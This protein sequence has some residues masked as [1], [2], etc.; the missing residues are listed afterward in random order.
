MF[1][2]PI[3]PLR[4]AVCLAGILLASVRSE[5]QSSC[6]PPRLLASVAIAASEFSLADLFAPGTCAGFMRNAGSIRLGATPLSGSP[7]VFSSDEMQG[8]L[9]RLTGMNPSSTLDPNSI[10]VPL[11]ITV[12]RAAAP[13]KPVAPGGGLP[14]PPVATI[15]AARNRIPPP[16]VRAGSKAQLLWDRD[17]IRMFIPVICLDGGQAGETVR[18]RPLHGGRVLPA[19]I[20]D[21]GLVRSIS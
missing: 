14:P 10:S 17:G 7:R 12:T 4:W 6:A 16:L 9:H 18:T 21:A 1:R 19:V 3:N 5:S 13:S 15:R 11:R 8:F 20:V 2:L